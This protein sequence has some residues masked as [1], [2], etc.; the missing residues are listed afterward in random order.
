MR[1]TILALSVLVLASPL[2]TA[3]ALAGQGGGMSKY[4]TPQERE[5]YREQ[6]GPSGEKRGMTSDQRHALSQQMR[7][8]W[9]AMSPADKQNLKAQLDAQWSALSPAQQQAIEQKVA[10]HLARR[11]PQAQPQSQGLTMD[12]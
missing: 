3:P 12:R 5:L 2:A 8:Q 4:L 10:R 11:Q 1:P 6:Q 7:Q 9:A